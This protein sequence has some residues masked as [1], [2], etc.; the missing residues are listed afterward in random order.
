ME[1]RTVR[2]LIREFRD[3]DFPAFCD[4]MRRPETHRY[5]TEVIPGEEA[6][7]RELQ[8]WQTRAREWPRSVYRLALTIPPDDRL[9]GHIKLT[10][11]RPEVREW[12][13]GWFVHPAHWAKGC[14]TEA[15][16]A[17]LNVAFNDLNAHRVIAFCNANNAASARVMEKLGMARDG[18]LRESLWWNGGW[19][20]EYLYAILDRD[21]HLDAR[22]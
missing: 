6:I 7:R 22:L 8:D 3:D 9:I 20:D 14:A 5:E 11:H 15:A 21:W 12:E 13:I 18:L 16:R 1:I 19:C 4:Y 17:L 10:L 2:L